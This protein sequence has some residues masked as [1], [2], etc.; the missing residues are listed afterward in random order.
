MTI[1]C[2]DQKTLPVG[3]KKKKVK[4]KEIQTTKETKGYDLNVWA[5]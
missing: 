3:S 4:S 2:D 1:S 5:Q